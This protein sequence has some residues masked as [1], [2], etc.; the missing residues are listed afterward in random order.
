MPR[1]RYADCKGLHSEE[2]AYCSF[3]FVNVI[4]N[5]SVKMSLS[6]YTRTHLTTQTNPGRNTT[7]Q[8]TENVFKWSRALFFSS[9]PL[10]QVTS[11][12]AVSQVL[13]TKGHFFP[14]SIKV[15]RCKIYAQVKTL[16]CINV[17]NKCFAIHQWTV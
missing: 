10:A 17:S 9:L 1:V 12:Q 6:G 15:L 14:I 16:D 7:Y 3:A 13:N 5:L 11:H 8:K 4:S 2:N